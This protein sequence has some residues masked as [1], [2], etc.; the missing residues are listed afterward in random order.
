[1]LVLKGC[2]WASRAPAASGPAEPP[3]GCAGA[4]AQLLDGTFG[5][6]EVSVLSFPGI[7][8]C[9]LGFVVCFQVFSSLG[10]TLNWHCHT[11]SDGTGE[12]LAAHQVPTHGL[13]HPGA[14]K[15]DHGWL[16]ST[17]MLWSPQPSVLAPLYGSNP[18]TK[19]ILELLKEE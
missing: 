6:L 18:C 1:M 2:P 14:P 12:A 11:S 3:Q 17:G 8:L 4:W 10:L 16:F 13:F 9:L 15:S 7:G 19:S 5:V